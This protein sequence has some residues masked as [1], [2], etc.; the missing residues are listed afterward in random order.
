MRPPSHLADNG[1]GQVWDPEDS[2]RYK[3]G[4]TLDAHYDTVA[5]VTTVG[6]YLLSGGH[7]NTICSWGPL[8]VM[9]G[10]DV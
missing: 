2:W 5:V 9:A 4:G 7:D 6:P 1:L 8:R 3:R 10:D